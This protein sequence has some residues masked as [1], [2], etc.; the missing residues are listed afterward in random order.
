VAQDAPAAQPQTQP[1]MGAD[2][3]HRQTVASLCTN[4]VS[5]S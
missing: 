5:L 3:T 4:R 1:N 2:E